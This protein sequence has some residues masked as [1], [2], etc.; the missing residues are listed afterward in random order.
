MLVLNASYEPIN[1]CT[2]RRA[3]VLVL[4]ERAEI[5]ERSEWSLHAES[6]TLPRPMVIRLTTY[7]RI[8][9]DAH[10]RKITRRA[11]FARDQWTCQYCGQ[12]RGNLTVD[13]VIPRSKGGD[14]GWENIVACC[15]P[16][17]RRKGDR[18]PRQANMVPR[19]K[20]RAPGSTV[21]I[22]VAAPVIPQ[23]V[24]AVP[25]RRR[26]DVPAVDVERTRTRRSPR[27]TCAR[28]A[29]GSIVA[30]VWAV[31]ATAVALIALLDDSGRAAERRANE[32]GKRIAASEQRVETRLARLERRLAR[33]PDDR[34]GA[35]AAHPGRPGPA[36]GVGRVVERD[37]A[38]EARRLRWR[39]T[40]G[41]GSD[42]SPDDGGGDSPADG[43]PRLRD[44]FP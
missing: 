1:V 43:L 22:H 33:R 20:P 10:R 2:V 13:H 16:C 38:G 39:A 17:N 19:T 9:R 11:V 40:P 6:M 26:P 23:G 30:G 21:F 42:T 32:T 27:T 31:A 5:L 3:A 18:L 34:P 14:S 25:L 24:G 41:S 12:E 37:R 28:C 8:P 7:V 35:A 4:K 36:G 15:A 44:L 29:G